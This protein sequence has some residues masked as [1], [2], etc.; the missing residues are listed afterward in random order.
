MPYPT[1]GIFSPCNMAPPVN[2]EQVYKTHNYWDIITWKNTLV[3][4]ARVP[5]ISYLVREK[6]Q[7]KGC[8]GNWGNCL[9]PAADCIC[10][11]VGSC[12]HLVV[13][14]SFTDSSCPMHRYKYSF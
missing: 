11:E 4:D 12:H 2:Y 10:L 7:P 5:E 1:P 3:Y 14:I 6:W 9:P 13:M 8:N